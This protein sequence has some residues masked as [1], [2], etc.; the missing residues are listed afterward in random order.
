M[1]L[2]SAPVCRGQSP[3]GPPPDP[4]QA[5]QT[6]HNP[7]QEIA[8]Q[9]PEGN[10]LDVGPAKLR[11]GGYVGLTGV[12]RSTNSG[13]GPA[14]RF[15]TT[16]YSD[17]LNG[18]VSQT[19]LNA[20]TS[21]LSVRVDADF[22][23]G[24][25]R[26]QSLAGY[27]EMDFSGTAPGNEA[28]TTTSAGFRLRAAFAEV[29][30]RRSFF[31]SAGQAGTL[32]TPAKD[33]LSM[34]PADFDMS[35]AVDT[36]YV[37][38]LVWGR[39]PQLRLTWRPSKQV[40]WAFSVE[41]PEQQ[42]G[43]GLITL[44]ACCGDDIQ[45]QYNTGGQQLDTPNL[46]PDFSS[47]IAFNP[48]SAVH[49]DVGGV[50]RVFRHTIA[51]YTDSFHQIGGGISANANVR[52]TATTRLLVQSSFGSGMGRYI[53]G[54][55]PDVAFHPDGSI[56]LI[57]TKSWVAGVEQKVTKRASVAGYYSGVSIDQAFDSIAT[58]RYIGFGFPGAPSTNNKRIQ[59]VTT[60]ASSQ[61]MTTTNRG[62]AQFLLQLSWLEREP[63]SRGSGP[64]SAKA[65][66][67]FA[68]VR[69]NLP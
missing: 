51:P 8:G 58:G 5:P 13:G 24:Q 29:R 48:R 23:D 42:I 56:Q 3:S 64:E 40:N 15:A 39:Y 68:Q 25:A 2:A 53:G 60:T 6:P 21:R 38:G 52:P 45:Q 61:L 19:R 32:M 1:L 11:I 44:P 50:V 67:F 35:Q 43:S 18:N 59:E 4:Q 47:R 54:L 63:W 22:S 62:S 20:E 37:A 26:F 36:N 12:F 34:W 33:Q 10:A 55:A 30:Y 49:L 9:T 69:Y 57:G 7:T 65:Y 27:F 16:P 14:T 17:T 46:L 41:N 31:L 28:V 66:L